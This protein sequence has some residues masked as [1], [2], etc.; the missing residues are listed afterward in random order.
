MLWISQNNYLSYSDALNNAEIIFSLITQHIPGMSRE[1]ICGILGNMWKESTVNPGIWE[2]LDSTNPSG[3]YGLT[4]WTPSTKLSP[5][6][7]LVGDGSDNGD[8]Q[9][10]VVIQELTTGANNSASPFAQW[11]DTGQWTISGL[12]STTDIEYAVECFM[13][14]YERPNE[15]YADL[16]TRIDYARRFYEDITGEV[17]PGDGTQ[18]AVL[19]TWG[20][21]TITQCENGQYSHQGSFATDFA[22]SQTQ[23]PIYA[24]FDM[25]CVYKDNTSALLFESLRPVKCA[26]GTIDYVHFYTI[27]W[28]N[29]DSVNVGDTY[30]KG[31]VYA[32]TGTAG[33]AT[34]DHVHLEAAKGQWPGV[35]YEQNEYGVYILPGSTHIYDI[36]SICNNVTKEQINITDPCPYPWQCLMDWDDGGSTPP[37]PGGREKD[38]II[39]DRAGVLNVLN[40][41][42]RRRVNR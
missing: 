24:P 23:V 26:D 40:A 10:L 5:R 8:N 32:G 42:R 14:G 25:K 27:H 1:A 17:L 20:S 7:S 41:N 33:E 39:L 37:T 11:Y 21:P 9:T 3:G 6:L 30:V 19:P 38:L 31:Q 22:Y 16:A 4:Q 18:L 35:A 28:D 2:N 12:M 36:F 34:G 15:Q 29:Y 13:R